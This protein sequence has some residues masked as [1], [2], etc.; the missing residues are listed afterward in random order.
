MI[1]IRDKIKCCGCTACA[2]ICSRNAISMQPDQEGFLYPIIDKNMCTNCGMCNRVCPIENKP[3]ISDFDIKSFVIRAKETDVLMKST[4]G[5]F[6]TP[7]ATYILEQNGIVCAA[8]Y[9]KRFNVVHTFIEKG[10][11]GDSLSLIRGSK[12]V[13]SELDHCFIHIKEFLKSGRLVC[14]VGTTCQVNGLKSFLGGN[15]ENL[16][17]VDLVCHGTPSPK[18]W[19][20]Y[21]NFQRNKYHS[22]ICEVSFRNKTYGYHSGTMKIRFSNGKV[23]YGSARVD[24]MLKSFFSEISSRPICYQCPFKTLARCSDFTIYDCWHAD[25]LV[26]GLKDDDKGYTNVIVQSEHGMEFLEQLHDKYDIYHTNTK[27]AVDLDGKMVLNSAE[28]HKKRSLFYVDID[29]KT[30]PDLVQQFIPITIID[31][32]IEKGKGIIYQLGI[33][34]VLKKTLK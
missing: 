30:M 22:D 9:G 10:R 7:L 8:S 29:N 26:P 12:Y 15:F 4:S 19:D 24:Y 14:F 34:N 33:Y 11:G 25:E 27:K 28:P 18:L 31:R 13:Q 23:Y 32:I 5:G 3:K 21:L 17:S 20:K 16:V 6:I 2:N 1:E